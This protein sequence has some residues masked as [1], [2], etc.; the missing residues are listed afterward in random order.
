MFV[1]PQWTHM[2]G[3]PLMFWVYSKYK[4]IQKS[5]G[6][7]GSGA[8]LGSGGEAFEGNHAGLNFGGQ[9]SLFCFSPPPVG[10]TCC[11]VLHGVR[12]AG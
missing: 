2:P 9:V 4:W 11:D 8:P 7:P 1:D 6:V 10:P 5:S 3:T 12:A